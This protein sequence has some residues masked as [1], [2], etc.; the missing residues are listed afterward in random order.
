MAGNKSRKMIETVVNIAG[1]ISP[2]LGKA[3]DKLSKNLDDS[4]IKMA[5]IGRASCRER[6]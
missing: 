3:F 1:E 6:V 5:E 2:S 4:Q